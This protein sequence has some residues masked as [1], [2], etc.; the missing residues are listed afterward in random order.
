LCLRI[1]KIKIFIIIIIIINDDDPAVVRNIVH[2][3]ELDIDHVAINIPVG[4][5]QTQELLTSLV[6]N[7]ITLS[8]NK[9]RTWHREQWNFMALAWH[10]FIVLTMMYHAIR[11]I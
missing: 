2:E 5:D 6:G 7:T 10:P 8:T 4:H 9:G 11:E 1:T 3:E